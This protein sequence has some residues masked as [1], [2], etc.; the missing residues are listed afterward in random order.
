MAAKLS[1]K[2]IA[3]DKANSAM[4]IAVG[5]TTFIVIMCAYA[6]SQLISQI[7]YQAKV[8]DQKEKTRDQLQKNVKAVEQLKVSY[9]EFATKQPNILGGNSSGDG[10]KDGENAR[11]ILDALPS[12]YDFPALTT[13]TEKILRNN[14]YTIKSMTGTD[15]ELNQAKTSEGLTSPAPVEMPFIVEVNASVVDKRLF[16]LFEKSIRPIQ[17]NKVLIK[18]ETEGL[19]V[20]IDAKT[21]FQPATKFNVKSEPVNKG[22]SAPAS[23]VTKAATK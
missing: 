11:I 1:S 21:Y 14:G 7:G 10:E 18:S 3:I 12:K 20:T 17:M 16:S 22:G 15:D 23:N 8:I 6:G 19:V 9:Q 2:H 5:L 13:S 4:F